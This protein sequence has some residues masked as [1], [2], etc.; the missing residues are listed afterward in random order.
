MK[1]RKVTT[2]AL[3]VALASSTALAQT[4]RQLH[5]TGPVVDNGDGTSSQDIIDEFWD[6]RC[7]GNISV[8]FNPIVLPNE[9]EM[10]TAPTISAEETVAAIDAGLQR[11][12]DNP[13]SFIDMSLD[14]VTELPSLFTGRPILGD[15]VAEAGPDLSVKCTVKLS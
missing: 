3:A 5:T 15:F 8:T 7:A 13:S 10:V 6:A 12:T 4:G 9:D 1:I 2:L 14:N 11:W